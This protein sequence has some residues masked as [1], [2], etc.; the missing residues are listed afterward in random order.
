MDLVSRRSLRSAVVGMVLG[1][2]HLNTKRYTLEIRHNIRQE[3]YLRY[4][5]GLLAELQK[6]V[7]HLVYFNEGEYP[8]IRIE[9][10]KHPL[11]RRLHKVFYDP[12]RKKVVTRK[13]LDYLD[14]RGIA[15]WYMD[16]GTVSA[17]RRQG[18]IHAYELVLN[19]NFSRFENELIIQYFAEVWGV[20]FGLNLNKGQWRLRM[21]TQQARKLANL[22]SPHIIPAMQHKINPLLV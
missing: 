6:S 17:K 4:K 21:G 13:G 5:A 2:A 9:T 19:T 15:I 7:V 14:P 8:G 22:I 16:N 3:V 10:Q 1:G 12:I 18:K 20:Q 11:Y